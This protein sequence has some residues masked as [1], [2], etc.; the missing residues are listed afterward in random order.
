MCL[1]NAVGAHN[2]II[3]RMRDATTRGESNLAAKAIFFYGCRRINSSSLNEFGPAHSVTDYVRPVSSRNAGL[4]T[5]KLLLH[6]IKQLFRCKLSVIVG[7]WSGALAAP[8]SCFVS[9]IG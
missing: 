2:Y 5:R 3:L 7:N 1:I 9:I 6:P 8:L 4:I